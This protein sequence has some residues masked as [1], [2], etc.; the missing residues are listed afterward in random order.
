M[1]RAPGLSP[2]MLR[3]KI[4]GHFQSD[5]EF[6]LIMYAAAPLYSESFDADTTLRRNLDTVF[7]AKSHND[8]YAEPEKFFDYMDRLPIVTAKTLMI[9]GERDWTC[10]PTQSRLIASLIPNVGL[11][12]IQSANHSVHLEKNTEVI[13]FIREHL[14]QPAGDAK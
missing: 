6:Q 3:E 8:L 4:F 7:Y 14:K 13:G 1:H 10:P 12:V 2:K 11:E 5:I 9:V